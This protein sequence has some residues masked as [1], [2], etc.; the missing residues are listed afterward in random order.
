MLVGMAINHSGN[1]R[2]IPKKS[3]QST[4]EPLRAIM[5]VASLGVIIGMPTIEQDKNDFFRGVI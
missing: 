3:F 1:I 5:L 2:K 4:I